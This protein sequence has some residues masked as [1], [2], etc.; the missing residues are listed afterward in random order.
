MA[1]LS[2][3]DL[4]A[5]DGVR[6]RALLN[7]C[8]IIQNLKSQ[9]EQRKTA[10]LDSQVLVG[11][12]AVKAENGEPVRA[13]DRAIVGQ[14]HESTSASIACESTNAARSVCCHGCMAAAVTTAAAAVSSD[15]GASC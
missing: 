8:N 2:C 5:I 11:R 4:V 7:T 12:R 6:K 9:G 3:R 1:S 14:G 15:V 13:V 10:H